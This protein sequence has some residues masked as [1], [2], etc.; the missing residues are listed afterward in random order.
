V[1]RPE[2]FVFE[3][4]PAGAL[5]GVVARFFFARGDRGYEAETLL[6]MGHPTLLFNLGAPFTRT[7]PEGSVEIVGLNLLGSQT[8]AVEHRFVDETHV[9]GAALHADGAAALFGVD[10]VTTVDAAIP[11]TTL[12][13][14]TE[15]IDLEE[16]RRAGP[17]EAVDA[18]LELSLRA[19][20]GTED[21][22]VRGV[23]EQL[24]TK[25]ERAISDL[26]R[27]AGLSHAQLINRFRRRVGHTP[28]QF[29]RI[30]RMKAALATAAEAAP[31][32]WAALAHAAGFSDQAH[33]NR[34]FRRFTGL[35]P[36][37][38][39]ARRQWGHLTV[40]FEDRSGRFVPSPADG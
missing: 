13:P 19:R 3:T 20:S 7:G 4:Y 18:L 38:Y 28:K 8:A 14:A 17:R 9:I 34:E 5:T 16:L 35:S 29:A 37:D 27:D 6:P 22:M 24:I 40:G 33:F 25:P 11:V 31:E 1:S 39:A 23:V 32:S 21:E 15:S 26:A 12:W 2:P 30:Q 10:A 36:S